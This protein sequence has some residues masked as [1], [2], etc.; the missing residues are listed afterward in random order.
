MMTETS[1]G[2]EEASDLRTFDHREEGGGWGG[3]EEGGGEGEGE[4]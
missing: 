1:G 4:E 3:R 2:R